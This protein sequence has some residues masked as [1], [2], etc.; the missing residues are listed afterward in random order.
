MSTVPE[1]SAGAPVYKVVITSVLIGILADVGLF[2]ITLA[3][4]EFGRICLVI[5]TF[6]ELAALL[7]FQHC[8][9]LQLSVTFGT[10]VLSA[11]AFFVYFQMTFRLRM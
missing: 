9:G 3:S 5:A 7:R 10:I 8:S 11:V 4:P 1:P 6:I 2:S